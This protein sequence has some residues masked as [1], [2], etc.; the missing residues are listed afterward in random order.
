[1]SYYAA[2]SG[3]DGDDE[4]ECERGPDTDACIGFERSCAD[5][6]FCCPDTGWYNWVFADI[7]G[8]RTM[9]AQNETKIREIGRM[10]LEPDASGDSGM[11]LFGYDYGTCASGDCT[12]P[13][14]VAATRAAFENFDVIF[15]EGRFTY[16][17]DDASSDSDCGDYGGWDEDYRYWYPARFD[18]LAAAVDVEL[19]DTFKNLAREQGVAPWSD[20][21][22]WRTGTSDRRV[23]TGGK[24]G[25]FFDDVEEVVVL[26]VPGGQP[27]QYVDSKPRIQHLLFIDDN[28]F[29]APTLWLQHFIAVLIPKRVRAGRLTATARPSR[30]MTKPTSRWEQIAP[31]QRD[32]DPAQDARSPLLVWGAGVLALGIAYSLARRLK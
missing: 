5:A 17:P 11:Q 23:F 29:V 26:G 21:H 24:L 27:Q 1:M 15:P 10:L 20:K 22:R 30:W 28:G 31:V 25:A 32:R 9:R 13:L 14:L 4:A 18:A 7:K 3:P 6:E 19:S 2:L 12:P 8:V 16:D